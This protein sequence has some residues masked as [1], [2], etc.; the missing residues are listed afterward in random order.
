MVKPQIMKVLII[1][2]AIY[3]F[4]RYFIPSVLRMIFADIFKT[5]KKK[6]DFDKSSTKKKKKTN[7]KYGEYIDY[8]DID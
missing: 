2:L 4:I 3:L 1:F 6:S 7:E 5:A 8:E